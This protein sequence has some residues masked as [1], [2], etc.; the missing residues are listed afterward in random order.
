MQNNVDDVILFLYRNYRGEF[1]VRRVRPLAI[2]FGSTEWHPKNQW[3]L[4]GF[5][6]DKNDYRDFALSDMMGTPRIEDHDTTMK[7]L[8]AEAANLG[9][10]LVPDQDAK[11]A[12]KAEGADHLWTKKPITIEARQ[13]TKHNGAELVTWMQ[14]N[15]GLGLDQGFMDPDAEGS[16]LINTPEGAMTAG[17]GDW[18]IKGING[19]FY[20]CKDEI[21]QKTYGKA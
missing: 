6:F 1:S 21:F 13:L 16:L 17:T 2:N 8:V 7:R 4:R 15:G 14:T 9:Y 12:E 11:E 3:L 20:P 18:I 19:E 10:S 5:D